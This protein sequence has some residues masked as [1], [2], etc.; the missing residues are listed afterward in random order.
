MIWCNVTWHNA[1]QYK[2]KIQYDNIF[3]DTIWDNAIRNSTIHCYTIW[4]N[5]IWNDS[6]QFVMKWYDTIL[7]DV[8]WYNAVRHDTIQYNLMLY[9]TVPYHTLQYDAI[10]YDKI[11]YDNKYNMMGFDKI[12]CNIQKNHTDLACSCV[13]Q[14][15]FH[16]LWIS[17][18]LETCWT[19]HATSTSTQ[20]RVSQWV[21]GR[22]FVA[23]CF[24]HLRASVLENTTSTCIFGT[25]GS[26]VNRTTIYSFI[27]TGPLKN[28]LYILKHKRICLCYSF[29]AL[30][31]CVS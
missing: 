25:G 14:W 24:V 22:S 7:Y 31:L 28:L 10:Q 11:W 19:T 21:S 9:E 1:I 4:Y 26:C 27:C 3:Y 13:L 5:V 6:I 12:L 18:D 17:A 30:Y 8:I 16:S 23:S 15:G 20:R 29:L 2:T